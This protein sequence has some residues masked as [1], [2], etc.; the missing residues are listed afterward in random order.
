[1]PRWSAR[2]RAA[3]LPGAALLM[4]ALAASSCS[5]EKIVVDPTD[6]LEGVPSSSQL[7]VYPDQ[8]IKAYILDDAG[9]PT[10]SVDDT[11][12]ALLDLYA[13]GPGVAH[14]II[15]DYTDANAFEIFRRDGSGFRP[16]KDF[17]L[18][19]VKRWVYGQADAF[20]FTD[21]KPQPIPL[22]EYVGRGVLQGTVTQKS[23]KTNVGK[24]TGAPSGALSY[25]ARTNICGD[26]PPFGEDPPDSLLPMQWSPVPAAA[27]YWVDVYQ[28]APGA[29]FLSSAFPSPVFTG[30][31][32]DFFLAYFPA[33]VTSYKIGDPVPAGGRILTRRT[34]LNNTDYAVRITAVDANGQLIAYPGTSHGY[35]Y[36]RLAEPEGRYVVVPLGAFVVHTGRPAG[37]TQG[38]PIAVGTSLPNVKV[39]PEAALPPALR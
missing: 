14:G 27:G 25:T 8:A 9:D 29:D 39:I 7:V 17:D 15:F 6:G 12:V 19:P 31:T 38:C 32:V 10:C 20:T 34:L 1:M 16:L 5:K 28:F 4:V 22:Q 26:I 3:G 24:I 2:A 36:T 18:Q 13:V 23:P 33:S 30:R 11:L 35:L 21:P 37:C